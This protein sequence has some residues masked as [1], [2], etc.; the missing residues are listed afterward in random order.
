MS[1]KN[2]LT[3]C[4]SCGAPVEVISSNVCEYC[5]N[6]IVQTS[7]EIVLSKKKIVLSKKR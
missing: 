5:K 2:K 4:P 3:K 1:D 6:T 7:N